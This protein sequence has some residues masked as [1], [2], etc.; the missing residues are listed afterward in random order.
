MH[1][2]CCARPVKDD[3]VPAAQPAHVL[4]PEDAYEPALH[5][6]QVCTEVAAAEVENE[7][8]A[9]LTHVDAPVPPLKLPA[10]P[11]MCHASI[12]Q[13][14]HKQGRQTELLPWTA[15]K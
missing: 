6:W 12:C 13:A 8:E 3:H 15:P 1:W 14:S 2:L 7:P 9:Q 11:A 4:E 5:V 10:L